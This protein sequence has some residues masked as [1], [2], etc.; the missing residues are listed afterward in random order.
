M[1]YKVVF[2]RKNRGCSMIRI[3]IVEDEESYISVLKEYL[4]RYKEGVWRA[5]RGY[6]L[7]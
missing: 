5:D 1:R 2:Y 6:G 7:P 3:A 4:E